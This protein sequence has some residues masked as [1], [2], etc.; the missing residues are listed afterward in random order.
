MVESK[1]DIFNTF[2]SKY[3]SDISNE[4]LEGMIQILLQLKSLRTGVNFIPPEKPRLP[5]YIVERIKEIFREQEL[6]NMR[7]HEIIEYIDLEKK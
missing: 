2:L 5:L 3:F 1:F 4:D 7:L 6:Q